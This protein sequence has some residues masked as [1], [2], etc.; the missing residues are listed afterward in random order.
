MVLR[1]HP[2]THLTLLFVFFPS[3]YCYCNT[4]FSSIKRWSLSFNR[5]TR[6]ARKSIGK[7]RGK[8]TTYVSR[9]SRYHES[10]RRSECFVSVKVDCYQVSVSVAFARA[11]ELHADYHLCFY[12]RIGQLSGV[13]C[14]KT[15]DF[16]N[17]A[18]K[19]AATLGTEFSNA[20]YA[21]GRAVR[22]AGAVWSTP[23]DQEE[24]YE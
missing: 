20:I 19:K 3:H 6:V 15:M 11:T 14:Y 7:A 24:P 23:K 8:V 10:Y 12:P 4:Q 21:T 1:I 5:W 9:E 22:K 17:A 18:K 16:F 13:N 2:R